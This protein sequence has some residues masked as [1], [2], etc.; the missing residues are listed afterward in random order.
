MIRV[1]W[2]LF[3][4][5]GVVAAGSSTAASASGASF[6]VANFLTGI[7]LGFLLDDDEDVSTAQVAQIS[8]TTV[9]IMVVCVLL[10]LGWSRLKKSFK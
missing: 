5:L 3:Q 6:T 10:A 8:V 1:S 7:G 2:P 9:G 4:R